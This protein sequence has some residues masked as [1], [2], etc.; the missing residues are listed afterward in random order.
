MVDSVGLTPLINSVA[1]DPVLSQKPRFE[2]S[3]NVDVAEQFEAHVLHSFIQEML[4]KDAN[5]VFGGGLAGDYWRSMMSEKL[6][7]VMAKGGNFGIADYL[8]EGAGS[9]VA[10][11]PGSEQLSSEDVVRRDA[12]AQGLRRN[13]GED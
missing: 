9:G 11:G 7:E 8:R 4:P 10:I 13:G 12:V 3:K 1:L 5:S 2:P 6:A